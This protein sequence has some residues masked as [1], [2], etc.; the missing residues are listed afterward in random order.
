MRVVGRHALRRDRGAA[1]H[2]SPLVAL[3]LA[4][5]LAA[6][7][8]SRRIGPGPQAGAPQVRGDPKRGE[9]LFGEKGCN[10]CHTISGIG[11][12]VGPNLTGVARRDLARERPGRTWP[13]APSYIRE[14]IKDPQ[15]YIVPGFPD[16]SPMPSAE[17]FGL[18]DQDINDLITY[19]LSVARP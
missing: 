12:Q 2:A 11:G 10:G 7:A 17:Q 8:C 4:V 14:S 9:E 3:L 15:A 19:L 13:D 5:V 16:P 18:S 1:I 6:G